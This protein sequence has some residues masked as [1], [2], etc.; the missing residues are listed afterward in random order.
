MPQE[1]YDVWV[2]LSS[3]VIASSRPVRP[4][5]R[6]AWWAADIPAASAPMMSTRFAG[7]MC[8][9]ASLGASMSAFARCARSRSSDA[10]SL[11]G[12]LRPEVDARVDG[13]AV[14]L[15][16]LVLG[17]WRRLERVEVGVE[18]LHAGGA[19]HGTRDPL[20]AQHPLQGE[21]GELLPA[22]LR[23]R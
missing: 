18:L 23:D 16:E 20:V 8:A 21:L 6:S 9:L 13:V 3:T 19:D 12:L 22:A 11:L 7:L 5:V 4:A 14:D 1:L 10:R 15:G 17:Q 2:P